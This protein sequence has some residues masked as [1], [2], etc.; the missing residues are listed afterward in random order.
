MHQGKFLCAAFLS[1]G[2]LM[3]A[4]AQ[5]ASCT[6]GGPNG[7]P[8]LQNIF[9]SQL[10]AATVNTQTACLADGTDSIWQTQG[11][12]GSVQIRVE[13]AGNADTNSYGIYDPMTGQKLTLFQGTDTAG[14]TGIITITN[15]GGQWFASTVDFQ[16]SDSG[17][18]KQMQFHSPTFGFY[19]A[20]VNNGTFF[21]N[22]A[23]NGD[24]VDHMYA[25]G[26]LTGNPAFEGQ[27]IQGWEDLSG[28]G[29]RD[30]QDF[31]VALNDITPVPLPA[32]AWL[33]LSGLG[34]LA[35]LRRRVSRPSMAAVA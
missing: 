9:D 23:L 16:G 35:C 19:L 34:A 11:Q 4:Q 15:S 25:Y 3:A 12:V 31:V 20:T 24:H 1:V 32:A 26:P 33:L 18:W 5:A 30:Y 13:L 22:T 17:V 2:G 10:G 27:Y 21:S 6:F 28:G 8:T 14:D 29:D 7:E